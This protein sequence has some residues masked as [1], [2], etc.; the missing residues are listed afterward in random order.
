MQLNQNNRI[1]SLD[2]LCVAQRGAARPLLTSVVTSWVA[3]VRKKI[4]DKGRT[5][6]LYRAPVTDTHPPP[7][8][9]KIITWKKIKSLQNSPSCHLYE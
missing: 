5:E 3:L 6:P 8:W 9:L 4:D 1:R 2:M 7:I